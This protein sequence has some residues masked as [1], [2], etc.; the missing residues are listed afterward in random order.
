MKVL[1]LEYIAVVAIDDAVT[2][3]EKSPVTSHARTFSPAG[4]RGSI[5]FSP[6][7]NMALCV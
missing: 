3:K 7:M 5:L 4:G 6:C 2:I 1:F